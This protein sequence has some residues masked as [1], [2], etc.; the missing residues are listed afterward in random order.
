[1]E[2]ALN[3]AG[4]CALLTPPFA[5]SSHT[6]VVLSASCYT[7]ACRRTCMCVRVTMPVSNAAEANVDS[8]QITA[9]RH[10]AEG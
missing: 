9:F 10:F 6:Y 5:R 7:E 4:V 8:V 3:V 1:M 2:F